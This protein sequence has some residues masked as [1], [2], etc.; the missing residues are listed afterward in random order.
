MQEYASN[1]TDYDILEYSKWRYQLNYQELTSP[2]GIDCFNCELFETNVTESMQQKVGDYMNVAPET[3]KCRGCRI[4]GCFIL[5]NGCEALNCITAKGV[6]FC[7]ECDEFP[8]SKLQPCVDGAEKYPQNYKLFN[9]CRIKNVGLEKWARE[10]AAAIRKLYREGTVDIGAG[11][12][13]MKK[14]NE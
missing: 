9:L 7:Y 5:P 8:C 13:F 10:E 6:D 4:S 14:N 2:C 12:K 1:R 11:P 3:V